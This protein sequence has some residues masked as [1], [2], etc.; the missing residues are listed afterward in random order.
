MATTGLRVRR[1]VGSVISRF[2][3]PQAR[4]YSAAMSGEAQSFAIGTGGRLGALLLLS[5][6]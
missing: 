4:L 5:R 2:N 1:P 6:L 3:S